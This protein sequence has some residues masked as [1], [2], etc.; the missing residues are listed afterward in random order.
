MMIQ[1]RYQQLGGN[2]AWVEQRLPSVSLVRRFITK[3]LDDS[4]F[5]ELC[6]AMQEGHGTK[7]FQPR[8]R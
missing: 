1:E 7:R 6:Q 8:I 4:S 2:F 5:S 3:F